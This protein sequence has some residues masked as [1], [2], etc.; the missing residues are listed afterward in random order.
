MQRID[1]VAAKLKVG[2]AP[3]SCI[4]ALDISEGYVHSADETK[5]SVDYAQLAVVAVVHL[6]GE[7]RELHGHERV[8]LHTSFAHPLEELV[9]HAPASHVVIYHPYFYSLT[10]LVY[11]GIGKEVAQWVVGNDVGAQVDVALGVG[12]GFEQG[13]E[14][15]IAVGVSLSAAGK[16]RHSPVLVGEQRNQLSVLVGQHQAVLLGK[17]QHTALCQLVE[18]VLRDDAFLADVLAEEDI[19]HYSHR[20]CKDKHQHPGHCL[21]RLPPVHEHCSHG[22]SHDKAVD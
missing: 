17:L 9:A 21:G 19:E 22:R 15:L 8:Y 5:Q 1:Y 2:V 3:A 6:P 14:E 16:E 20:R 11:Q 4:S 10:C 12:D 7:C 13:R 18:G